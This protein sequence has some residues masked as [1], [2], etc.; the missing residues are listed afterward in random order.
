MDISRLISVMC[1]FLLAVCL[2]LSITALTVLRNTVEE[3]KQA[4]QDVQCFLE[5]MEEETRLSEETPPTEI[6]VDNSVPVDVL[7]NR[8]CMKEING[9]VAIYTSDGYLVRLLDISVETLPHADQQALRQGIEVSS[10][11]EILALIQDFEAA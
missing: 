3:S 2:I 4:C 7:S 10:W 5:S 11:K 8:F 1:V 6:E 9:K